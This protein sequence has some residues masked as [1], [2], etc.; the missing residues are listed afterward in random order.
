M[1]RQTSL[2]WLITVATSNLQAAAVT[3]AAA[4]DAVVVGLD[5]VIVTSSDQRIARMTQWAK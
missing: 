1:S 5:A 3:D 4:V 2:T